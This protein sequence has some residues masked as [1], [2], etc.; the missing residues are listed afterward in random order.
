M[1]EYQQRVIEEKAELDSKRERL[2]SFKN[3]VQFAQLPWQE[4]ERLNTQGHLMCAYSAILGERIAAFIAMN[5]TTRAEAI[6]EYLPMLRKAIADADAELFDEGFTVRYSK[7]EGDG[8]TKYFT[9]IIA[10]HAARV[11]DLEHRLANSYGDLH[12]MQQAKDR[13]E[14]RLGEVRAAFAE[15]VEIV[16]GMYQ[17]AGEHE[18]ARVLRQKLNEAIQ[19]CSPRGG[20]S[21]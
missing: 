11:A 9:D 4:Q 20:L 10:D 21:D 12:A 2:G 8:G 14:R 7:V 3:S 19:E 1:L 6:A 17:A 13:A 15:M 18:K 5:D 16:A